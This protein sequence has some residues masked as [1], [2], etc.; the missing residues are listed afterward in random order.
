MVF[1]KTGRGGRA[2]QQREINKTIILNG[3]L[4]FRNISRTE[5]ARK[6]NLSK[7]T[8]T[9]LASSL[10]SEGMIIEIEPYKTKKIGRKPILLGLNPDYKNAIAVKVGVT[11]TIIAKIDFSMKIKELRIFNTPKDP[12]EFLEKLIGYTKEI[13]SEGLEKTHAMGIGIPGIVDNTFKNVVTAPNLNWKNVPLG[14]MISEAMGENFGKSIPV[15]MDN[16]ANMAVVAEG[17]LGARIEYN[18]VNI[19]Y[20]FIGEGVGTGLILDGKLYRGKANTAGEFGH[21]IISKDGIRCKC[22]NL[23]CWERYASL[24]SD[25]AKM[26]GFNL[27][28]RAY[29]PSD[30]KA[31]KEFIENISI[32]IINIVNGLSPDVIILGGPLIHSGTKDIWKE[33]KEELLKIISKRSIT[34]DTGKVRME[35]TSFL[36]YPA[37]LVG[38]GIWAFW[39]IFEG[40]VL[41]TV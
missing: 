2:N 28:E 34:Q 14:D 3:F 41:S 36:D 32:G 7:S 20:I 35:L 38:A 6:F 37:E 1:I 12:K 24:G 17:M 31:L 21:M 4:R 8:V 22:G 23:G 11:H 5:L 18:D 29:T 27:E 33:I 26:A 10:I 9:R 13:F 30:E 16:E 39:D 25:L 19:V 15:K 40:P